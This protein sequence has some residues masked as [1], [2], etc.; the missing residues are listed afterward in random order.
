MGWIIKQNV[1]GEYASILVALSRPSKVVKG[2]M[3]EPS[4]K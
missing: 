3:A 1:V 4:E 2:L